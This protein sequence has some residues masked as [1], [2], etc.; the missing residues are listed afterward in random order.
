M[1]LAVK[2]DVAA[3]HYKREAILLTSAGAILL[4]DAV[5]CRD[6]LSSLI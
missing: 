4:A 6:R 3:A 1:T 5:C 2:L